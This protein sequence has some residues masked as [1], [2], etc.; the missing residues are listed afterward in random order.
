MF[1]H[2]IWFYP[3]HT[4]R[5]ERQETSTRVVASCEKGGG[6]AGQEESPGFAWRSI[7]TFLFVFLWKNMSPLLY[8]RRRRDRSSWPRWPKSS[9]NTS[10]SSNTVSGWMRQR[11]STTILNGKQHQIEN[12]QQQLSAIQYCQLPTIMVSGP[13]W[14]WWS[15]RKWRV[16]LLTITTPQRSKGLPI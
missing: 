4:G 14:S 11:I 16:R 15:V 12:K 10:P 9:T 7:I 13:G 6:W 8:V 1:W 5:G 2:L 3:T